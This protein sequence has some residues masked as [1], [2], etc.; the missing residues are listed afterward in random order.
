MH[1]TEHYSTL[2]DFCAYNLLIVQKDASV[3]QAFCCEGQRAKLFGQTFFRPPPDK[4]IWAR[5]ASAQCKVIGGRGLTA[6]TP[7]D[8]GAAAP[9]GPLTSP[10][11]G[12]RRPTAGRPARAPAGRPGSGRRFTTPLGFGLVAGWLAGR[13]W[14]L[15]TE[16]TSRPGRPTPCLAGRA[17]GWPPAAA[18]PAAGPKQ[19]AAPV[20]GVPENGLPPRKRGGSPEWHAA[21][22][23]PH[24]LA[25]SFLKPTGGGW[26]AN[27]HPLTSEV[28]WGLLFLLFGTLQQKS[29]IYFF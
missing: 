8:G 12:T 3:C 21:A 19:P 1:T 23:P 24:P 7:S 14:G 4:V 28:I 27:H 2:D 6:P 16:A 5:K 10:G 29:R 9:F 15:P 11:S 17:A 22:T 13:G 25:W 20:F 26:W 18:A